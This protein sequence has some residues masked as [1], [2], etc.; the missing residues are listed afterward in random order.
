MSAIYGILRFD[1]EDAAPRDMER[2]GEILAH[3]GPDGQT[4]VVFKHVG[5]GHCLMHV[6]QEDV[7]EAQ[8]IRDD[9]AN[10][11]LVADLR[12]DN[13]EE[14]ADA[15]GIGEAMLREMPDSALVLH[16]YKKWGEDAA[17]HLLGDFAFAAWN[18]RARRL[19]LVRDAVGGRA[20]V[21]QSRRSIYRLR[22]RLFRPIRAPGLAA[23]A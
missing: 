3:R 7:F 1:G 15:C 9:E 17:K 16:A 14:L 23:H 13:R 22:H 12:I 19:V 10:L 11:L 21:L 5:L 4:F 8:P 20:A 6:N 2:V 18:A